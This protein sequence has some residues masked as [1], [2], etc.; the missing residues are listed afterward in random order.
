[1]D[2]IS[3]SFIFN[4]ESHLSVLM[5]R[6]GK[7]L[8]FDNG[9]HCDAKNLL[10]SSASFEKFEIISPFTNMGGIEGIFLLLKRAI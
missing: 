5:V 4:D 10:K 7:V 3:S 9:L 6:G 8:A 2:R 1:M